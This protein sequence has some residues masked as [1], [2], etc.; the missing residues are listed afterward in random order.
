MCLTSYGFVTQCKRALNDTF[1]VKSRSPPAATSTTTPTE[2]AGG[3]TRART[4]SSSTPAPQTWGSPH[5]SG[6]GRRETP[7]SK[8]SGETCPTE[9]TVKLKPPLWTVFFPVKLCL[10]SSNVEPLFFQKKVA[11]Q[12]VTQCTI[13]H[14]LRWLDLWEVSHFEGKRHPCGSVV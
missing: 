3:R 7:D 8:G 11:I 14:S 10:F 12:C 9:M 4:A 5:S 6:T 2:C 1:Q 13:Q